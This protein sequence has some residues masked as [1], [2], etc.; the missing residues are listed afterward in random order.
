MSMDLQCRT[1][2]R[3]R[4][5]I[6]SRVEYGGSRSWKKQVCAEGNPSAGR[7]TRRMV[8]REGR[9]AGLAGRR[10]RPETKTRKAVRSSSVKSVSRIDHSHVTIGPEGSRSLEEGR[11]VS[12]MG[13]YKVHAAYLLD[14][15]VCRLIK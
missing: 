14:I 12:F 6:T 8:K 1:A 10:E 9:S 11:K 2:Y 5:S 7:S 3:I 13:R 4:A 15:A